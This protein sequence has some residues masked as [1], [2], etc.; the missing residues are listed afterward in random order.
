M[1]AMGLH[2]C[3]VVPAYPTITV[4]LGTKDINKLRKLFAFK[5][6]WLFVAPFLFAKMSS[7]ASEERGLHFLCRIIAGQKH[8]DHSN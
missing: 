6:C 2:D 7:G 3:N 1:K 5:V 8:L 4:D